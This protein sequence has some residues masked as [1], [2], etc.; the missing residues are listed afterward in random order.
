MKDT[1]GKAPLPESTSLIALWER[2]DDLETQPTARLSDD[3]RQSLRYFRAE[4]HFSSSWGLAPVDRVGRWAHTV[5]RLDAFVHA[6]GRLPR[7]NN[8]LEAAAISVE[9]RS[10]ADFVRY[11]RRPATR[12]LHCTYQSLRLL[13]VPGFSWNP[14][15]DAWDRMF[16]AFASFVGAYRRAPRLRSSNPDEKKLAA[17][18]A[19]QRH[20]MKLGTLPIERQMKLN[21]LSF[22]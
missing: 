11:Q 15:D 4:R 3:E 2:Y 18:S 9:E 1:V 17:W 19:K 13:C 20:F 21:S 22:R 6:E 12:D 5:L 7:E 10:L 8:R 16:E 14:L